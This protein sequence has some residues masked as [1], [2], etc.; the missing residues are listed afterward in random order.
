MSIYLCQITF[1]GQ[2]ILKET[3]DNNELH[4]GIPILILYGELVKDA[5][6]SFQ[7]KNILPA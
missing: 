5:M 4:G 6:Y 2:K 1:G 3:E 7:V